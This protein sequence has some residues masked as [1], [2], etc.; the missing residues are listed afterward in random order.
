MLS[1]T[2]PISRRNNYIREAKVESPWTTFHFHPTLWYY[3]H[4]EKVQ[5]TPASDPF[6]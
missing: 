3:V 4:D 1:D 2:L 5:V 6:V